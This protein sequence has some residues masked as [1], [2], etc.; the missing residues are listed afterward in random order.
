ME[1]IKSREFKNALEA[2]FELPETYLRMFYDRPDE[3][4]WEEFRDQEYERVVP[5]RA[6]L[7]EWEEMGYWVREITAIYSPIP[8]DMN[9]N[10]LMIIL[11][12]GGR[13]PYQLREWFEVEGN[14]NRWEE[15]FGNPECV[16]EREVFGVSVARM[17]INESY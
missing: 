16:V 11:D 4:G 3:R 6:I 10:E 1:T 15:A 14:L 13:G 17:V 2:F 12:F 5:M 8:E 9:H 7:T